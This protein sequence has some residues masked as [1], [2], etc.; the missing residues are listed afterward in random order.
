MEKSIISKRKRDSIIDDLLTIHPTGPRGVL[1]KSDYT[2]DY[3]WSNRHRGYANI[4]GPITSGPAYPHYGYDLDTL[5]RVWWECCK[6]DLR[7]YIRGR[8]DDIGNKA[9]SRREN[10]LNDRLKVAHEAFV[11]ENSRGIWECRPFYGLKLFVMAGNEATAKLLTKTMVAGCGIKVDEYMRATRVNVAEPSLLSHYNNVNVS[12]VSSQ[13]KG[14]LEK[15]EN[16]RTNIER[17]REMLSALEDFG[18]TQAELLGA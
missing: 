13:L 4:T 5:Q 15:L 3:K 16:A 6:G 12:R 17:Y 7:S 1:K 10:R 9:V 18:Q 11:K 8:W 14:A 2:R